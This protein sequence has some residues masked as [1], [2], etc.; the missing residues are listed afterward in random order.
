MY[1][2]WVITKAINGAETITLVASSLTL[3]DRKITKMRE[4]PRRTT[5]DE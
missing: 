1:I 3:K 4:Y 5:A 2:T